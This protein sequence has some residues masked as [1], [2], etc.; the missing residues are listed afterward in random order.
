MAIYLFGMV[1]RLGRLSADMSLA[2]SAT[3]AI[4]VEFLYSSFLPS[5]PCNSP[6]CTG[7]DPGTIRP[8]CVGCVLPSCN[9]YHY[10]TELIFKDVSGGAVIKERRR[11]DEERNDVQ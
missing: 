5:Y 2:F 11:G 7:A 10:S 1:Q 6:E 9:G 4:H 3:P 8:E